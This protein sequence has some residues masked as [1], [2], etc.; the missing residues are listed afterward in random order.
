MTLGGH[1]RFHADVVRAVAT[2]LGLDD[3]DVTA[4][5]G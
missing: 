2:S 3:V 5:P 1:R 4:D